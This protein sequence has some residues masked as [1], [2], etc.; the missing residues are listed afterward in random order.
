MIQFDRRIPVRPPAPRWRRLLPILPLFAAIVAGC[1]TAVGP[2]A[3]AP[4]STATMTPGAAMTHEPSAT[5]EPVGGGTVPI[6][7]A[8]ASSD[9]AVGR[10]RFAFSILDENGAL[11]QDA[12]TAI[13]FF[14]L[15][16]AVA[17]PY[18][19]GRAQFF[20]AALEQAGLY[21]TYG[22]FPDAGPWGA[23]IKAVL[24]DGRAAI[25][26]RVRFEIA[27]KAKGLAVGEAPPPTA[28]RTLATVS[29]ISKLTSDPQ[30]DPA[31]YRMT[32]DEAAKSGRPTVVTFST[33]AFCQS[34]ICGPVIE[35]VKLARAKWGDRVNFI[36]I[37]VYAYDDQAGGFDQS[38]LGP[39]MQ[40]WN[41][42]TEPWV[43][44]LGADGKVAERMEGSVT[45]QELDPILSRVV[46][47][48]A[49][50]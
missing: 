36:H 25:P 34:R 40:A 8:L 16:E 47:E 14:R 33:P 49:G 4:D 9:L 42:A 27:P 30:P 46:G 38:E 21:V 1:G 6:S 43:Y 3:A 2:S 37:E 10:Q 39:E 15:K 19:S 35:E 28:N 50:S 26:Q 13:Q 11:V 7:I 44:V 31:L 23:E 20:P 29:E 24:P 45:L 5:S 12:Q 18:A 32:V 17:E 22:E 48:P 41:L